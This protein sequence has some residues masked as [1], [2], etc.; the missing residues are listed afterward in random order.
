MKEERQNCWEY[1]KCGREPG[2]LHAD[3]LGVCPASTDTDHD[4]TNNGRNAGRFCWAVAG[5]LCKG[6]VQGTF[7]A[8]FESCLMCPFYRDVERQEGRDL[9]LLPPDRRKTN[10]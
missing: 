2:G 6:V 4:G 7:A 3:E 10:P 8:K 1:M 9:Q 5:T